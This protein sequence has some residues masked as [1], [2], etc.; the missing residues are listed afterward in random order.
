MRQGRTRRELDEAHV[1]FQGGAVRVSLEEGWTEGDYTHPLREV[2]EG[3][4]P[5]PRHPERG[6]FRHARLLEQVAALRAAYGE[7]RDKL[8]HLEA[9]AQ[10]ESL[11]HLLRAIQSYRAEPNDW[12]HQL[13][14]EALLNE[15]LQQLWQA[16]TAGPTLRLFP[17]NPRL[18]AQAARACH[19][20]NSLAAAME[21]DSTGLAEL[22]R[23]LHNRPT[24]AFGYLGP[25]LFGRNHHA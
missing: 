21:V 13:L 12:R 11:E 1:L 22:L 23:L 24:G 9:L 20:F 10:E 18:K 2:L 16:E 17:H 19:L 4:P 8:P 14:W 5:N 6:S 7:G 25:V 15:A 3:L